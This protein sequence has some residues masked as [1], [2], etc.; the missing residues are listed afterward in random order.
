M[1]L[2][3][4]LLACEPTKL[5]DTGPGN[6]PETALE[7]GPDSPADTEDSTPVEDSAE[8]GPDS[9]PPETADSDEPWPGSGA[10][11]VLVSDLATPNFL[12]G[13]TVS[14]TVSCSGDL[15]TE[16]AE[17]TAVDLPD[18]ASF[19]ADTRAFTWETG[20]ADGGRADVVFSVKPKDG[21]GE[22][23]SAETVTFWVADDASAPGNVAVTP[24]TYTE[25]WGL[26]VVHLKTTGPISTS[27]A[28]ATVTWYGTEY[29]ANLKIRGASSSY[30]PKPSYTLEFNE[31]ELPMDAWG[32]TRDHLLLLSTFDDN[33]YVRQKLVYDLWAAIAEHWED[34]RMTP[35]TQ[36][37]VVYKNGSYF[38]LYVALDRMDN[39]FLDHMG[40]ER[41][42]NL[43]KATNHN[44][45]FFLTNVYGSAKTSL[46]DG[47]T[48][49]EG[50]PEDDFDD[51]DELVAFTGGSSATTLLSESGEWFDLQEFMDWFLLVHYTLSED[52]AGKN[53]YLY[54]PLEGGQFRYGPWDFNHSW[55]QGWYTY[56]IS[57]S[58][59]DYYTSTN[60]VFWAI[61]SDTD[62]NAELWE[63]FEELRADGPFSL[64]WQ[65]QTLDDYYDLIDPSAQRDWD[66][67]GSS[68]RSY[69]GWSSTRNAYG[70]WT[71]FEGEKAYLYTW[72]EERVDHFETLH[73]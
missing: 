15:A 45:N 56:R 42:A 3:L 46:H 66:K 49:E 69:G 2:T 57:S 25:E 26:P 10:A 55:G 71:D 5:P 48:K 27:Y 73:P 16:D 32:V 70:D 30:Y 52:S 63:R 11:C 12:E 1:L 24:A 41:D 68:Y 19:D 60:R 67:W 8:T 35:R 21:S 22:I 51:L 36:F 20:P 39:E 17:I 23:P 44:A 34:Q 50:E 9:T 7:T 65:E 62:A 13:D 43:Y 6:G 58:T 40:F 54:H 47:Y 4:A 53:S 61:Q 29:D 28:S 59:N 38:G 14:F 72:V 18:G 64:S 33:S 31:D 37:V